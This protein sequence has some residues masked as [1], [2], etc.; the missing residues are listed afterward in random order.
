MFISDS[1]QH[2]YCI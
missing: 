2:R 1:R